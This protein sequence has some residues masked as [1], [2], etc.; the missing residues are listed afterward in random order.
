MINRIT[1]AS[2]ARITFLGLPLL[3][4]AAQ[5]SLPSQS[6]GPNASVLVSV[7]FFPQTDSVSAVQF[8]LQYDASAMSLIVT[9]GDTARSSGKSVYYADL[10]PD[11][12]RFLIAGLNQ[13]PIPSGPLV[14]LFI[15]LTQSASTGAHPLAFSNAASTD[16]Y[17]QAIATT[18]TDGGVT[19]EGIAGSRLQPEGVLNAASSLS[20]PVAPGEIIT[21]FGS[22]IGPATSVLFDDTAAPLLYTTPNQINAVVPYRIAGQSVTQVLVTGAGR[23]IAGFPFPVAASAPAI[24]TLDS[25]GVGQGVI[26]NEDLS[27]NSPSNPAKRGS[28]VV[29]FA[30]GAG[31]TDPPGADGQV[32]G[33]APPVPIL[34]VS[35]KIG[36]FAC[37]VLYAGG[38]PTLISGVLQANCRI[39]ENVAAGDSVPVVLTVGNTASPA[40]VTLAIQ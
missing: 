31:Q 17:G 21:L 16:P 10:A 13:N 19:V 3:S 8:D 12:R 36:G 5:V 28:I 24:F 37:D 22:G 6:A 7:S 38:V 27:V 25:T 15:N 23:V 14:N 4:S 2:F 20:G 9:V 32:A 29:I 40:G 39:A 33:D 1:F 35:V 34:P 30:T 26:L 11:R 18:T